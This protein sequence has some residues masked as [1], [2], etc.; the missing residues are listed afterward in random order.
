MSLLIKHPYK[1]LFVLAT[2]VY[3][4][5]MASIPI[6]GI[7]STQYASISMEM[8]FS[9]DYLHVKNHYADYL[10]KPPLLS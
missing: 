7:D 3:I 4:I 8:L 5:G 1:I 9:G 10:D 2:L 6:M